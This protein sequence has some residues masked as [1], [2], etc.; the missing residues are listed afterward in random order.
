MATSVNWQVDK[1]MTVFTG[2]THVENLDRFYALMKSQL[3]DP[4]LRQDN[5]TRERD[6][7]VNCL[8]VSLRQSN[9]EELGKEYLYNVIYA[10]HPYGHHN[11]GTVSSLR[12]TTIDDVRAFYREHYNQANLV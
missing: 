7:A 5:F 1:E 10:G 12:K 4:G 6:D 9:D 11:R 8:K 3:L 2:T